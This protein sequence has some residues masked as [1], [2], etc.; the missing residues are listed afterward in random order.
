MTRLRASSVLRA[1][2]E[3]LPAPRARARAAAIALAPFAIAFAVYLA[4]F[5]VMQPAAVGDEPHYFLIAQSLVLDADFDL[6]ND[7]ASRSRTQEACGDCFPL[8]RHAREYRRDGPIVSF[9]GLGLPLLLAPAVTLGGLPLARLTMV[10]IAAL[11]AHQLFRLLVELGVARPLYR[12]LAWAAVAFSVPLVAFS[13]QIYPELPGALLAVIG[14]RVLVRPRPSERA[15]LAGAIAGAALPWLNIRFLPISVL[16]LAGLAYRAY[17]RVSPA[18]RPSELVLRLAAPYAV[19]FGAL[20]GL[21]LAFY[22]NPL[23]GAAYEGFSE[24]T[25]GSGG[26]TFWHR[27]LLADLLNPSLGWI[28]YAPV[29]WLG[30]AGIGCAVWLF[31]GAAVAVL[32]GVLAYVLL[33][34]SIGQPTGYEFPARFLLVVIPLVAIPLAIVLERVRV[35]RFVFVPL[36]AVSLVFALSA[37]RDH[38]SLYPLLGDRYT[39]RLFGVRSIQT[40]FPDT[41]GDRAPTSFVLR[42]ADVAPKVGRLERGP[43]LAAQTEGDQA[44]FMMDSPYVVFRSGRY[45]VRFSVA[46][47]GTAGLPVGQAYV[48]SSEG[49]VLAQR[50]IAPTRA[51]FWPALREVRLEF[52]TPGNLPIQTRVFFHGFG[53]LAAGWTRVT[54]LAVSPAPEE[55]FPDWP[56][57]FLWVAGTVLVG[58]LFVQVMNR[59][60][61]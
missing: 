48:I 17:R 22:G 38:V 16:L 10:L 36:F 1:R 41:S 46:G 24:Q 13:N 9:H 32:A 5:A 43:I 7:Y 47:R 31:R 11:L 51:D 23:P 27:Y 40:A 14:L 21:F 60:G 19:S 44:G 49:Q 59:G 50:F 30:L 8:Q 28:P 3:T 37:A 29:H 34:E 35:A 18:T 33:I 26:W 57:A 52:D 55:T 56:L 42:P 15:L 58:A 53:E 39:A 20:A 54:P 6:A 61:R 2:V 25:L 45:L 4:T 12:W